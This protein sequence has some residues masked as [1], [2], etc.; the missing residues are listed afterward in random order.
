MTPNASQI[1]DDVSASSGKLSPYFVRELLLRG[2]VVA[3]D[4]DDVAP[5]A[6]EVGLEVA[7]RLRLRR[8]SP[9]CRPWDRNR[10][11]ACG[12][13]NRAAA[14]RYRPGPA[15]P[16]SGTC[17]TRF[18]HVILL[19]LRR[20]REGLK[21]NERFHH[22]ATAI[23]RRRARGTSPS[24]GSR[25][26]GALAKEA[27][28]LH[29]LRT[30]RAPA[31]R[32]SHRARSRAAARRAGDRGR[33]GFG[34]QHAGPGR[35]RRCRSSSVPDDVPY[36]QLP[37]S[38]D[39]YGAALSTHAYLH[40][41]AA[42]LRA[43]FGEL[44][45]VLLP[46]A[47]VFVT[48]G[49][50]SDARYGLGIP[51]DERSFAPGD[52]DEAG[53]PHAYFDRDGVVE[54]LHGFRL[55]EAEEVEVDEIVGRWAHPDDDVAG[56]VH[57][58]VRATRSDRA[59][60]GP[61]C[62]SSELT[63]APRPRRRPRERR[64]RARRQPG[65]QRRLRGQRAGA[66]VA[67]APRRLGGDPRLADHV[68]LRRPGRPL[69]AARRRREQRRG[70]ASPGPGAVEQSVATVPGRRYRLSFALAGNP[71][72]PPRV[73]TLDRERRTGEADVQL[74]Q[75]GP[76]PPGDGLAHPDAR[77][78]RGREHDDDRLRAHRRQPALGLVGP[79]DRRRQPDPL[80]AA[81]AARGGDSGAAAPH[82]PAA[83][84]RAVRP[85]RLGC[86]RARRRR[87]GR[88]RAAAAFT[89][90]GSDP[91]GGLWSRGVSRQG[92]AG[93]PRAA[94]HQVSARVVDGDATMPTGRLAWSGRVDRS[95]PVVLG[96]CSDDDAKGL[97]GAVIEWARKTR[98]GSTSPTAT[99]ATC[100]T[101][102]GASGQ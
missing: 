28:C 79:G 81:G 55:D 50:F 97:H 7:E 66:G 9:A 95:P 76:H 30:D 73:K 25:T 16:T 20:A 56:R 11:R 44:R 86:R 41:T 27:P 69:V 98:S 34:A 48:L 33:H 77:L 72:G 13:R 99:P 96:A 14:R 102:A 84:R 60:T 59:G 54:L 101:R 62:T 46:D 32:A 29:R 65:P 51:F 8:C 19:E 88:P 93:V 36:T 82:R 61:A 63:A 1:A 75:R 67:V 91:Y 3:A 74:R 24:G 85:Q 2:D 35:G 64:A 58:F 68:G 47:P 26:S 37:G 38:R 92:A 18:E 49:S 94:R 4:A 15:A 23:L 45:R 53:I 90:T 70:R 89:P 78:H 6:F 83:P 21:P 17:R 43:G 87:S 52:G 12:R 57:W 80:G 42:K 40:G 100:S 22:P 10:R 39:M 71:E 5:A 31:R